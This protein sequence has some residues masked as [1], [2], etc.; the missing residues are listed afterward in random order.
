VA[1]KPRERS[2]ARLAVVQALYQMDLAGTS[3]PDILAEFESHWIGRELDGEQVAKAEIRHFRDIA[4]GVVRQQRTLDPMID[5]AL[6]RGWPLKRI[7]TLMRAVLRAGAYELAFRPEVPARVV[8]SEYVDVAAAFLDREEI[9]M[10]NAVLDVL[11]RRTRA[12]E[13]ESPAAE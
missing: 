8:I 9:G 3:V 12:K 4:D 13:F 7:E 6:E 10:V 1:L 5:D 11:A 2:A